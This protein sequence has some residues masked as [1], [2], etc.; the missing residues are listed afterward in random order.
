MTQGSRISIS[1]LW[2]PLPL[3]LKA[4]TLHAN[5]FISIVQVSGSG[6]MVEYLDCAEAMNTACDVFRLSV[7]LE[8]FG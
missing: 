1:S 6:K 3:S 8:V 5:I 7:S 4:T 2:G